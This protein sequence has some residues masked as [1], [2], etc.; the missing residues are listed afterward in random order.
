[1]PSDFAHSQAF[2]IIH[3]VP[4][5]I[6][7][8]WP[9]I[10][11]AVIWGRKDQGGLQAS[12]KL[13]NLKREDPRTVVFLVSAIVVVVSFL[14]VHLFVMALLCAYQDMVAKKA[15]EHMEKEAREDMERAENGVE[16]MESDVPAGKTG[17]EKAGLFRYWNEFRAGATEDAAK[18][19]SPFISFYQA[20]RSDP[21]EWP[22]GK[23]FRAVFGQKHRDAILL[24]SVA[25]FYAAVFTFI[26]PGLNAILLPQ[27]FFRRTDLQGH[28]LDFSSTNTT[29]V[30]WFINNP[31]PPTCNWQVSVTIRFPGTV[32][33]ISKEYN[34][35][36]FTD[37]LGENQLVDVLEPGRSSVSVILLNDLG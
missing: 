27:S 11:V 20:M 18:V 24:V 31:I 21:E 26:S 3:L 32:L 6:L 2:R 34:G 25:G 30:E 9:Y 5:I 33:S 13:A 29:C 16:P 23:M 19:D 22:V 8:I 17:G 10:F 35:F 12:D 14:M 4:A 36:E 15:K 28:E 37:C 7:L 1:M